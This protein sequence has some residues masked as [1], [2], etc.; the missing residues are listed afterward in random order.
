MSFRP[1]EFQSHRLTFGSGSHLHG[2]QTTQQIRGDY[3]HGPLYTVEVLYE[4]LEAFKKF[5]R[6]N[7][8]ERHLK[9]LQRRNHADVVTR[10][11]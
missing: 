4:R 3:L 10:T 1:G 6:E 2:R 5:I 9:I 11:G 7:H 8:L